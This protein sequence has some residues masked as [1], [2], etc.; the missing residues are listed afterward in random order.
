MFERRFAPLLNGHTFFVE[1]LWEFP[2]LLQT[3]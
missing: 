3:P 1:W 2:E